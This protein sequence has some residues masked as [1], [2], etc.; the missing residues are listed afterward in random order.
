MKSVSAIIVVKNNPPHLFETLESI[1]NLVSEIIIGDIDIGDN[2][3]KRLSENIKIKFITLR[4]YIPFADLIKEDLK[5]EAKGEYILYLDP[6]EIFPEKAIKF[7]SKHLQEYD[8]YL[9]PR[10]NIIFDKWIE[11]SR[12]WPDYQPRLFKK[13]SVIWPKQ[14][15]PIP[16]TIGK[17]YKFEP[18][19]ENAILHYNYDNIDQYLEKAIRYAK[20]EAK[21]KE[22]YSLTQATKDAKTEFISRYFAKDGFKD[23]MHGFV[24]AILQMFY[25]FLVYFYFW[26]RKKYQNIETNIPITYQGFAANLYYESS[27]W[28]DIKILTLG[29]EKIKLKLKNFLLK[30]LE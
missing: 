15:H 10:K 9:F 25:Y 30:T 1:K 7:L 26:E 22:N 18:K 23:G 11:H 28:H 20:T 17:E 16:Q 5:I 2:Y 8:Y 4:S 24:L 3:R 27:F 29:L 13:D 19:E 21:L 14:I 6:D 12:W